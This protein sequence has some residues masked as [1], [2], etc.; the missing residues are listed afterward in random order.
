MKQFF[1]LQDKRLSGLTVDMDHNTCGRLMAYAPTHL[2]TKDLEA[3]RDSAQSGD[4]FEVRSDK[5]VLCLDLELMIA[6]GKTAPL[7]KEERDEKEFD[8]AMERWR[9]G[10]G[11][12][13]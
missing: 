10:G 7:T 1:L 9:R 2:L 13:L 5:H 6:E 12:N 8:D 4:V 11:I 3:W